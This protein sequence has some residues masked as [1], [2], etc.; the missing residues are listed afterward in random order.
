MDEFLMK[1][2][3]LAKQNV[4]EGG[5]PFG[6][7]LVKEGTIISEGV[8]ELHVKHDASG[9]AEMLAVRR[10]QMEL[11]TDDLSECVMYA[12]GEPCPMCFAVMQYAGIQKV[13]FAETSE[14]AAR[15][16]LSKGKEIYED[17]QRSKELR[18]FRM[19][20][21]PLSGETAMERFYNKR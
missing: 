5:H 19:E 9:H 3:D 18:T 16:G 7:V 15:V 10:A 17:L 6:A 13:Y 21:H 4:D 8:N 20:H 14:E 2:V 12:S 11:E 1:A